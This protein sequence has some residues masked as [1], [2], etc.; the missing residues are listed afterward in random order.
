M[1]IFDH[2]IRTGG[3]VLQSDDPQY[4]QANPYG[5][6][7]HSDAT[8]RSGHTRAKDQIL[9]TNETVTKYGRLPASWGDVVPGREA[10]RK[11]F[12]P[13]TIDHDSPE[14]EGGD[15]LIINVWRAIQG[16]VTQWPLALLDAQTISQQDVHP[17]ILNTYDNSPGGQSGNIEARARTNPSSRSLICKCT[18]NPSFACDLMRRF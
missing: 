2:A 5:A 1:L 14:G 11:F 8:V 17:S 15:H 16:P 6:G 12:K 10:Q 9:G 4:A 13:E 7:V 3:E 18:G